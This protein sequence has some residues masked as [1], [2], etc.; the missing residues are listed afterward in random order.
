M[1][2]K[3]H[4]WYN[5]A[6]PKQIFARKRNW[7]RGRLMGI[8]G[9]LHH[10]E[11]LSLSERSLVETAI[12]NLQNVVDDWEIYTTSAKKVSKLG[13]RLELI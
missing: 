4:H 9:N 11:T 10:F 12:K 6:T 13:K 1:P 3:Q 7:E 5:A 8:I 2:E